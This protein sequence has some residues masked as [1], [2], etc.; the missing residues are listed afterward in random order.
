MTSSNFI[1]FLER[2]P[3]TVMSP[4]RNWGVCGYWWTEDER[5]LYTLGAFRDR[6]GSTG[7]SIGNG[8]NWAY[9]TRLTG[10]PVYEPD[11]D[12]FRLVHLGGAFS[13]RTP[14]NGV[15]NFDPRVGSSLLSVEDNPQIPFLPAV[16]I[17]TNSYQL[18]NLQAAGVH[19]PFSVQGEWS[20][21]VIQQTNAGTV[22]VH[23][24]YVFGSYFLTGEHRGYNRTRG[25][26]DQV[27][28]LRPVIRSRNDP[29]GG[30]GAVELAVRFSYFD[31]SSPNLPPDVNG[32]SARTRL[33]EPTVGVN[34]YLNSYT[35][36]M[37]N[38][39][40]DIPDKVGF[41]PTVAHLF[42]IRTAIY[43]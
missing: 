25:S 14:P 30:W 29:R 15:L 19:G 22:F 26:F 2:S 41:G 27:D 6:T 13:Q 32:A 35:R 11:G 7:V 4:A 23:G 9:T 3:L 28:V 1:T 39:T 43:W 20:A 12:V 21:A 40:V 36:I 33:Y 10:L 8:D 18:Y 17:P 42:G 16:N 34:W 38:Y 24:M 31:M 5:V 37:F